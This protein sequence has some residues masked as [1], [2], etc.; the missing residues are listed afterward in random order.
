MQS[1]KGTAIDTATFSLDGKWMIATD[2][3]AGRMLLNFARD[4][5]ARLINNMEQMGAPP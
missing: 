2:P 4:Y 1:G 5:V 3:A